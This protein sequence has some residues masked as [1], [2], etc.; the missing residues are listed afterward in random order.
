LTGLPSKGEELELG[1]VEGHIKVEATDGE[2]SVPS[3]G[4]KSIELYLDGKEVGKPNGS[5]AVGPCT[6]SG[7]WSLNGAEL[8]VGRYN[9]LV[10]ATDNADNVATK[11]FTLD[12][13][14]AS[15]VAMGPGS[16]NPESGD[17]AL[18]ATD[19][20]V[21]GGSGALALSRHY[22]SRNLKEGE[23]GPLGPQWSVSLG[24]LASLEVLPDGSIMVVGPEGLTHFSVKKGGG[25]EAPAGDSNLTLEY[26][27]TNKEYV[28]K[29]AAKGTTTGFTLPGGAKSW[30]PTISKG[31]V[32]TDTVTDTYETA[33]PE[34]GKKIVDPKLELAP[35]GTA[36]CPAG[37]PKKWE[38]G[39]RGLEFVY[40]NDKGTVAKGEN[41]S[42]WGEYKGRLG[43][44]KFIAY[45]PSAKAIAEPVVAKYAYD[46][47]GRLRAEWNP[48]ISPAMKT[49]YGY[50]AEGH[51]TALTAPGRESWVFTYGALAGDLST[52]RLIK[53]TQAPASAKLWGGGLPKV[54][55]PESTNDP[56]VSGTPV[57]G[58]KSV[59]VSTGTWSNEPVSYAYHWET[60]VSNDDKEECT[61]IPGANSATYAPTVKEVG[62]Q[63]VGQ[64]IATNGG[65]SVVATSEY[66]R[67][68]KT[69]E[70]T[71]Y[72]PAWEHSPDGI[73]AGP[74]GNVW[75][76]GG[77]SVRGKEEDISTG[78]IGKI[79]TAGA[80]TEYSL[81]HEAQ[82]ITAGPGKEEALWFT[83]L[84]DIGKITTAGKPT[85]YSLPAGS[86]AHEIAVGPSTSARDTSLWFTETGKEEKGWI[87]KSN[88][89][90]TIT[91]YPLPAGSHPWG[92]TEGPDGNEWFTNSN[93]S[94]ET[95]TVGKI[96]PAGT[97]TEHSL[98]KGSNPAQIV[99]GPDGNL[100]FTETGTSK[101][102]KIT[103]SGTITEYSLPSSAEIEGAITT[104]PAKEEALWFIDLAK[105]ERGR[106]ISQLAEITTAGTITEYIPY[107]E[108]E[109]TQAGWSGI[110]AGSDGN[111]WFA[112][113]NAG[114]IGKRRQ[115]PIE[116]PAPQPGSTIEYNVP[117]EG[118]GA[119]QQMGINEETR[120][121]EPEKWAQ[122]DDPAYATAIFPPEKPQVWPATSNEG[123]T[124]YYMDSQA[125][126]VNVA[127]PSGG[128]AT[129]EYNEDNEVERSLSPDNRATALK[130]KEESKS[131]AVAE[132]L[133]TKSKYNSEGQLAETRGPQ[134]IV[135]LAA[136]KEKP[137][138]EVLARNH[139][140]YSYDEGAPEGET[141][142]LVTR[143]TDGAETA[144]GEEFDV[145]T[146]R[147]YYNGQGELGW[148][149]REPTS[150][151]TDP[152]GLAPRNITNPL[153]T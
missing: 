126:T 64:V 133:D 101:I 135:R 131:A 96:T 41:K 97:I 132:L 1:E 15:P 141:Y 22:D 150:V 44:V 36:S 71:E 147:T 5:C 72:A 73:T 50:D 21:S 61:A 69:E 91:E 51:V 100:W 111:L 27:A 124:V 90:G 113:Q 76:T 119:P 148:T 2:G 59:S 103:P 116:S 56:K 92:V 118:P 121:A 24:S 46:Q 120:K 34:A 85:E 65:G 18:E 9:M 82:G 93:P 138:E 25:F 139:V 123:A 10:R 98:P 125:R 13:Y 140:K 149:L 94:H 83:E 107:I 17:F 66:S 12:V 109:S 29:D 26:E 114:E 79:T 45:N 37:E 108:S 86:E 84:G 30:M 136:G 33:E 99:S 35:H 49:Y 63:L 146:T 144:S 143:A 115:A 153:V 19:V 28:L 112:A 52:G 23:E 145:R 16:V 95:W 58:V 3:S 122:K 20:D 134:H 105:G 104:G 4:V 75:F 32:A 67:E 60:C 8:G 127:S 11:E 48:E 117:L 81:P 62:H 54:T 128:V 77:P 68:V 57:A 74:D 70:I 43:E 55:A 88:T 31:P 7:E 102:G 151:T 78:M 6:A 53:A 47:Q 106:K 80:I 14:H 42:E 40:D 110:T 152:A 39:C 87:G 89:S 38:K 137:D 130:E 129:T 142:D